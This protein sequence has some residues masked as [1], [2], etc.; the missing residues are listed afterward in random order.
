MPSS[1]EPQSSQALKLR[2]ELKE[3]ERAFADAHGGRKP[4]REEVKKDAKI[5]EVT[6]LLFSR[7]IILRNELEFS[8]GTLLTGV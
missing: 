7:N 2:Q 6:P 8:L 4:T 1:S 5:G 3:W